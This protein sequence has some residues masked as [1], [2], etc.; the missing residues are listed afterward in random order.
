M[1]LNRLIKSLDEAV[2]CLA[3]VQPTDGNSGDGGS[4]RIA[5]GGLG[6]QQCLQNRY[7]QRT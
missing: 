5:A 2:G 6:R 4:S 1:Q 3:A 7:S